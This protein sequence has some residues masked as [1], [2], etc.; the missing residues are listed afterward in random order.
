MGRDVLISHVE[1]DAQV[2]IEVAKAL[3]QAGYATWYYERDSVPGPSYL[4]QVNEAIEGCQALLLIVSRDA[5]SSNQVTNEVVVAYEMGK[6][7]VPLLLDISH[8]EFQQRQRAWR[9]A[10]GAAAS[11]PVSAGNASAVVSRVVAGL[12]ALGIQA[13]ESEGI[14]DDTTDTEDVGP[15]SGGAPPIE[16]GAVTEASQITQADGGPPAENGPENNL[17]EEPTS[18]EAQPPA[19]RGRPGGGIGLG[20]SYAVGM[21]RGYSQAKATHDIAM[22]YATQRGGPAPASLAAQETDETTEAP[23]AREDAKSDAQPIAVPS[24]SVVRLTTSEGEDHEFAQ[25]GWGVQHVGGPAIETLKLDQG[26]ASVF[27]RIADI[28]QVALFQGQKA[29]GRL[30]SRQGRDG[31]L[32]YA[33]IHD[34]RGGTIEG[35]FRGHGDLRCVDAD[36]DELQAPLS[37]IT[38]V[39]YP[40][41]PSP[42]APADAKSSQATRHTLRATDGHE[43][44]V[45]LDRMQVYPM[46]GSSKDYSELEIAGTPFKLSVPF[47]KIQTATFTICEPEDD[48]DGDILG[49][50]KY[51]ATVDTASGKSVSGSLLRA[52]RGD[53]VWLDGA[54]DGGHRFRIELA[55]VE[56]LDRTDNG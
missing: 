55:Y 26:H 14:K 16:G 9:Q 42:S 41:R 3:E 30:Y 31:Y 1:E 27:V 46:F 8:A 24:D 17:T 4:D 52:R 37:S 28:K 44:L 43:H 35:V 51:Q 48:P 56:R 29:Q 6:H 33:Q 47:D 18:E 19:S 34:V 49:P 20:A 5:L 2:A 54:C 36:G 12:Q 11:I 13:S 45:T 40:H 23:A 39:D 38:R 22:R 15:Q 50:G 21:A 53:H 32:Q 7:L 10:L 25:L